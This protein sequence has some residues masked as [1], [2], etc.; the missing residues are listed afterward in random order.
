MKKASFLYACY[1]MMFFS[2]YACTKPE[3]APGPILNKNTLGI[4]QNPSADSVGLNG[5]YVLCMD[6]A[7]DFSGTIAYYDFNTGTFDRN[8]FLSVNGYNLGFYPY[9]MKRYGNKIYVTVRG[10]STSDA[11]V[12]VLDAF[13]LVSQ[14]RIPFF[15]SGQDPVYPTYIAG[16]AG[17]IFVSCGDG[18]VRRIDTTSLSIDGSLFTGGEHLQIAASGNKLYV[19]GYQGYGEPLDTFRLP[20]IDIPTF[21]L[22]T[23]YRFINQPILAK[24]G[25]DGSVY[26]HLT[27]YA[28]IGGSRPARFIKV[29][30]AT[31]IVT[32]LGY[33]AGMYDMATRGDS[34]WIIDPY[35]PLRVYNTVTASW[36]AISYN[37]PSDMKFTPVSVEVNRTNG[38]FAILDSQEMNVWDETKF[39]YYDHNGSMLFWYWIDKYP[40]EMIFMYK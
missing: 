24:T 36:Q 6:Q 37:T 30:P 4:N 13:T 15:A 10:T 25:N 19:T 2:F 21:S 31:D 40:M 5:I 1:V 26:F 20:V 35:E 16:A 27:S 39:Y 32:D 7:T 9:D 3:T 38:D 18:Y 34:L 17:K 33:S 28:G 29:D 12:E 11:Y 14:E 22:D 8:R 23:T